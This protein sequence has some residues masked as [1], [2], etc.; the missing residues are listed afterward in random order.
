MGLPLT[1]QEWSKMVHIAPGVA[2]ERDVLNIVDWI[3][4]YAPE[5]DVLYLDPARHDLS[6][7]D[8]PY[9]II[10]RCRDGQVRIVFSCWTLDNSVKE[11]IIAADT[12]HTDVLARLE[13][14]NDAV[15][16]AQERAFRDEMAES[17]DVMKH[18]LRNPKT[19]YRFRNTQ[20][21]LIVVED[22]RGVVKRATD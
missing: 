10:E 20:N 22:D 1:P 21:E 17:H 12:Q 2:V 3:R 8:P 4:E 9:Q 16:N 15:R 6:P 14:N 13:A 18:I 19:T 5:L 7:S 11:R